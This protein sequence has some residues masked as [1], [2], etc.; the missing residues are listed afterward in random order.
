M[1]NIFKIVSVLLLISMMLSLVTVISFADET[2]SNETV[3][4][5]EN[6]ATDDTVGD[7]G[8]DDAEDD[9]E[10]EITPPTTNSPDSGDIVPADTKAHVDELRTMGY[11][12]PYEDDL[13]TPKYKII[14]E[15]GTEYVSYDALNL[16]RDV[17]SID[18]NATVELL[19]NLYH[20]T[21]YHK[22][23]KTAGINDKSLQVIIDKNIEVNFDFAGYTVF[24]EYKVAFFSI[25]G[26][27]EVHIYSSRPGAMLINVEE[28]KT[29]GGN[30]IT[31]NSASVAYFGD[32]GEYP[33]SNLKTYSAGGFATNG[34][35]QMYVTGIDC[36]RAATDYV[37]YFTMS[38]HDSVLSFENVR[39]FGVSRYL[40]IAFRQDGGANTVTNNDGSVYNNHMIFKNCVLSNIGSQGVVTGSFFRYMADDNNVTFEGCI[41][42]N[43]SFGC[44]KYYEH[45]NAVDREGNRIRECKTAVVSFDKHCSY[46][47]LPDVNGMKDKAE[48]VNGDKVTVISKF[49]MFH[50]P[51]LA[52]GYGLNNSGVPKFI[53]ANGLV[54]G[55]DCFILND[56]TANPEGKNDF[57][58]ITATE[59]ISGMFCLPYKGYEEEVREV[60]WSFKGTSYNEQEYWVKGYTP[61]PYRLNV[62]KD[63]DYIKYVI[64]EIYSDDEVAYYS[65]SPKVDLTFKLN[66]T[67]HD[68][69]YTNVY[70]PVYD[71]FTIEQMV[72]RMSVAGVTVKQSEVLASEIVEVEGQQYY[73]VVVPVE[74]DMVNEAIYINVDVPNAGNTGV[75]FSISKK[76]DFVSLMKSYIEGDYD[77]KLKDDLSE[78]LYVIY[79]KAVN[80]AI[81]PGITEIVEDIFAER[82]EAEKNASA[83]KKPDAEPS[84]IDKILGKLGLGKK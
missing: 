41:F 61:V 60:I 52:K 36:Y 35:G 59:D 16:Y 8:S 37:G 70:V 82:I 2:D 67:F 29:T 3:T 40:Q 32:Y 71:D 14:Y 26:G 1:K 30:V 79:K 42:D 28:G 78:V 24:T 13:T 58:M 33:G 83:E 6:N 72:Y 81:I 18:K 38:G 53:L 43:V 69:V 76:V 63:T 57:T 7:D 39:A 73:K 19:S 66:F 45:E 34:T 77:K 25:S 49:A 54:S 68:K 50:F 48:T 74:Y 21:T 75:S 22:A 15:D 10:G 12:L 31:V 23:L 84:I 51:E 9:G 65:I 47:M 64:E 4:D 20:S 27:A 17:Y 62:P 44:E 56:F 46:N 80:P 11:D 5:N 55:V